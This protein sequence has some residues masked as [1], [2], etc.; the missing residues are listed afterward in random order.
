MTAAVMTQSVFT[1]TDFGQI[2]DTFRDTRTYL[3][4][5]FAEKD[6]AKALGARWDPKRVQWYAPPM[7]DL[8]PL[9]RWQL[10]RI[11]LRCGVDDRDT[12]EELGAQYDRTIGWYILSN[13]DMK[14]FS[15]F[16][17]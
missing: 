9:S 8:A 17:P 16:L 5:P 12:V 2:S 15:Q 3:E 11:Y 10:D 1:Q 14:P 4:V 6:D 13:Q 7:T